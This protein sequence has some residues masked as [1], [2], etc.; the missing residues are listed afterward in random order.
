[1]A[2]LRQPN[3]LWSP[4]AENMAKSEFK[5]RIQKASNTFAKQVATVPQC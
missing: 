5:K 2:V 1:M 3:R 4:Y